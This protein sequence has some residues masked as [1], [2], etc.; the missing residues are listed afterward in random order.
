[1]DPNNQI[2]L[3]I[4]SIFLIFCIVG[5]IL[6][7]IYTDDKIIKYVSSSIICILGLGIFK[8]ISMLL[9]CI[10][11]KKKCIDTKNGKNE[12]IGS[13]EIYEMNKDEINNEIKELKSQN[14][15]ILLY[16]N[17]TDDILLIE[18]DYEKRRINLRMKAHKPIYN[19][20]ILEQIKYKINK[21]FSGSPKIK[22]KIKSLKQY[23]QRNSTFPKT[24]F[25]Q[26][27]IEKIFE[28]Q[29][30]ENILSD[31]L[32]N[33]MKLLDE[34][35]RDK[36]KDFG[37]NKT[38]SGHIDIYKNKFETIVEF[39]KIFSKKQDSSIL[40]PKDYTEIQKTDPE[41][42][43]TDTLD[44]DIL[45]RNYNINKTGLDFNNENIDR[46]MSSINT[47]NY[48]FFYLFLNNIE[49]IKELEE[50]L[51]CVD[52]FS[53]FKK[54]IAELKKQIESFQKLKTEMAEYKLKEDAYE[55]E[56]I[57]LNKQN[58]ELKE[59]NKEINTKLFEHESQKLKLQDIINNVTFERD[60]LEKELSES[61]GVIL[62]NDK[63]IKELLSEIIEKDKIII[64]KDLE[65]KSLNAT[66]DSL[67]Q[68]INGHIET[69]EKR[70]K[71]IKELNDIIDGLR[72]E[73]HK[74]KEKES[75]F[76]IQKKEVDAKQRR[77]FDDDDSLNN[78]NKQ[79]ILEIIDLRKEL[80][81]KTIEF[82]KKEKTLNEEIEELKLNDNTENL[83]E[84]NAQNQELRDE[85][86]ILKQQILELKEIVIK[87]SKEK[88]DINNKLLQEYSNVDGKINE[89]YKE[90]EEV[91]QR[92]KKL[93]NSEAVKGI[94]FNNYDYNVNEIDI[95]KNTKRDLVLL[96]N[97]K[98]ALTM[99]IN[100][101]K[102]YNPN[103]YDTSYDDIERDN[104]IKKIINENINLYQDKVNNK[105]KLEE[106]EKNLEII[107]V[108]GSKKKELEEALI[109]YK[110]SIQQR[111]VESIGKNKI[112][113][114]EN[115]KLKNQIKEYENEKLL[116][117]G[118]LKEYE[119]EKVKYEDNKIKCES[120][121][122]SL[123]ESKKSMNETFVKNFNRTLILLIKQ[124]DDS[125]KELID[126]INNNDKKTLEKNKDF[127]KL[128][129]NKV[130]ELI[131]KN[132]AF[133]PNLD[134]ANEE[135]K[136]LKQQL[137]L[138]VI[139]IQEDKTQID[140]LT[141]QI[142]KSQSEIQSK[143]D[144]IVK[145][146][147]SKNDL[148]KLNSELK[149]NV[150]V[151][152][153]TI[154][155]RDS[156]LSDE[157]NKKREQL[158]KDIEGLISEN[159]ELKKSIAEIQLKQSDL[160]KLN[161]ELKTNVDT[162]NET[163][164]QRDS[165]SEEVNKDIGGLTKNIERLTIENESLK[166][167]IK[168]K[169]KEFVESN[170]LKQTSLDKSKSDLEANITKLEANIT[171]L[172]ALIKQRDLLY[173]ELNKKNIELNTNIEKLS[174]ENEILKQTIKEKEFVE[175][176]QLN[177]GLQV[178][179]KSLAKNKSD[180]EQKIK[181]KDK[182]NEDL[183]KQNQ[184]M[185]VK[186]EEST[187]NIIE[188]NK[189]ISETQLKLDQYIIENGALILVKNSFIDSLTSFTKKI[190]SSMFSSSEV[191]SKI[192]E[193]EDKAEISNKFDVIFNIHKT[194]I[195]NKNKEIEQLKIDIAVLEAD[196][197]EFKSKNTK[198]I[199]KIQELKDNIK[200][201]ESQLDNYKS[202]YEESEK[203]LGLCTEQIQQKNKEIT[204]IK[205]QND[206]LLKE[207]KKINEDSE[208]IIEEKIK[209]LKE[210]YEKELEEIT[211]KSYTVGT[212]LKER[213]DALKEK[214]DAFNKL[215]L[216]EREN[217]LSLEG[218]ELNIK[219]YKS[220]LEKNSEEIA[221]LKKEIQ[222]NS[223]NLEK[224]K[225]YLFEVQKNT[226][227]VGN[228]TTIKEILENKY[229]K[230]KE[231]DQLIDLHKITMVQLELNIKEY[232]SNLDKKSEDFNNLDKEKKQ[233]EI[234]L[235]SE[236][237]TLRKGLNEKIISEQE[238]NAKYKILEEQFLRL[239]S[240]NKLLESNIQKHI[241]EIKSKDDEITNLKQRFEIEKESSN[242][243]S[244][245]LA[246][247][248]KQDLQELEKEKQKM[249]EE[250]E[251]LQSD[252]SKELESSKQL[253]STGSIT[254]EENTKKLNDKIRN[255]VRIQTKFAFINGV[256][257]TN[258][259]KLNKKNIDLI[260]SY[261]KLELELNQSKSEV[262]QLKQ[263]L[264]QSES[265]VVQLKQ[266]LEQ[267]KTESDQLKQKLVQ[268][269][270][271]VEQLNKDLVQ[272]KSEVEQLN[273][274]LTN[275]R[276]E[277][278]T[279]Q[280]TLKT[281][282]EELEQIKKELEI[283]RM[284]NQDLEVKND[285]LIKKNIVLEGS[286]AQ[287]QAG[288]T[289]LQGRFTLL[290]TRFKKLQTD[291]ESLNKTKPNDEMENTSAISSLRDQLKKLEESKNT[292]EIALSSKIET[293]E[294]DKAE[295]ENRITLSNIKALDS[296]KLYKQYENI[297]SLYD[298][299]L[300][301]FGKMRGHISKYNIDILKYEKDLNM[302]SIKL[303][304]CSTD[305][306]T[307]NDE[308]ESYKKKY[309]SIIVQKEL[310]DENKRLK[311]EIAELK[312]KSTT[313]S[314]NEFMGD[315][316]IILD[317]SLLLS[318][319]TKQNTKSKIIVDND[320]YSKFVKKNKRM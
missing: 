268:S 8:L 51:E 188:F 205:N 293:L 234:Q 247:K 100:T 94:D 34:F 24:F 48:F 175:S 273:K 304:T 136:N 303:N 153:E 97:R 174:R 256:L 53:K 45:L 73:I 129:I 294:N 76:N 208:R 186:I 31:V 54:K 260:K 282:S 19:K 266:N 75:A 99:T 183:T 40:E 219:E 306:K 310:I 230:G 160:E 116:L 192:K 295:L 83:K 38:D 134:K 274:D 30:S 263:K 59:K 196:K 225:L 120:Q 320:A 163:I 314:T 197:L 267:S 72:E 215:R 206:D 258:I 246:S 2:G 195:D 259:K 108:L 90:L 152:K 117:E 178:L 212:A 9:D 138:S 261:A 164:K 103:H 84:R 130:K 185:L 184:E 222:I 239:Q 110:E 287:L 182:L 220:D 316:I 255:L 290:D 150:D 154:K 133:Q 296:S 67:K 312:S 23:V 144:E 126:E 142:T 101:L 151:L 277:Y 86:D 252:L 281:I 96:E 238:F 69:I 211:K 159:T 58:E 25:N 279:N 12:I 161:S 241:K 292:I 167:T 169:E 92:K 102:K 218:I 141:E 122:N 29:K 319:N 87:I 50:S 33:D 42:T 207:I 204:N 216:I 249:Q 176:N 242:M 1:M 190:F 302:C 223:E 213:D 244:S 95:I 269:E 93:K 318:K 299:Q 307:C 46:T 22:N 131:E 128:L 171:K 202:K 115:E 47:N 280:V 146:N 189:K 180:L 17:E 210:K 63:K 243:K 276:V 309:E 61:K 55:R 21:I 209:P 52:C 10:N 214:D 28:D 199:T 43:I 15:K 149:A 105:R 301:E 107:K 201:L 14:N 39:N 313:T 231:I 35:N 250:S 32:F 106:F 200:L 221:K 272:S 109:G 88:E 233:I 283:E 289:D 118:K 181:E 191:D 71:Q 193:L 112:L 155:Q 271:E 311:E 60:E 165:L 315:E 6:L 89:L 284:K 158:S 262:A 79:I 124:I 300:I 305:L 148:E 240:D 217:Q 65:L 285:L 91:E 4:F 229:D 194:F 278:N 179:N 66:I 145:I 308:L 286:I 132:K 264:T 317:S 257:Q 187:K 236:I 125:S 20:K 119:E 78:K 16:I 270:S 41:V 245:Q 251:K 140:S 224:I 156:L 143:Q 56:K 253:L 18:N 147:E 98:E 168:D 232:K 127:N 226:I 36:V 68:Q 288:N 113:E 85:I 139:K 57:E 37:L 157:C 81:A 203:N 62:L 254:S 265:E 170:Q 3:F 228:Y 74:Y 177:E 111:I 7:I 44:Y 121:I 162:L 297:S 248:Y 166:Q 198:N 80:E 82:T 135:I 137:E 11:A 104:I 27:E 291:L 26:D 123:E 13:K 275:I 77:L 237:E 70:D 5:C 227:L 114:E 172:E 298:K 64:A 173:E 49:K 235:K